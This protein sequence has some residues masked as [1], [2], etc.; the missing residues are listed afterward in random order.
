[1][2]PTHM[3]INFSSGAAENMNR[4]KA[5]AF[6]SRKIH[7]WHFPVYINLY[8]PIPCTM[9]HLSTGTAKKLHRQ[10]KNTLSSKDQKKTDIMEIHIHIFI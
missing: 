8:R 2:I 1:M 6:S 10:N 7:N 9:T 3:M 5:N 4:Q